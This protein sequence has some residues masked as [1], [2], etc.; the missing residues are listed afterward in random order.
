MSLINY[1]L[2]L[3]QTNEKAFQLF[4]KS[5][6]NPQYPDRT[7]IT[8]EY[9]CADYDSDKSVDGIDLAYLENI[10]NGSV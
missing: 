1:T 9:Y 2:N 7:I 3:R 10:I 4:T 8:Q 6:Y 5:R